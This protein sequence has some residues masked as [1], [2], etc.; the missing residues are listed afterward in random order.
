M[1]IEKEIAEVRRKISVASLELYA[2]AIILSDLEASA[3]TRRG[4]V[5]SKPLLGGATPLDEGAGLKGKPK[6]EP[7]AADLP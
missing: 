2:A 5:R 4:R 6:V 1:N 3:R 7:R